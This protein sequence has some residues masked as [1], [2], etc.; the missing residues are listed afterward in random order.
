M[1]K[2][3]SSRYL[4]FYSF[5]LSVLLILTLFQPVPKRLSTTNWMK[6]KTKSMSEPTNTSKSIQKSKII[7]I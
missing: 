2:D 6:M 3:S 4:F 1:P 5:G 7:A